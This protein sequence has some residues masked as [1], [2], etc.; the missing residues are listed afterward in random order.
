M[1]TAAQILQL[2]D[3]FNWHEW[4]QDVKPGFTKI[5]TAALEDIGGDVGNNHGID[6]NVDDPFVTKHMTEYIG[7][8]ITQLSA[9]SQDQVKRKIQS[10][11]A[12]LEEDSSVQDL[13]DLVAGAVRD[14]YSG[15]EQARAL[16]I[17]RTE[18]AIV[19]NHANVLGGRQAGF[20][21]FDVVDGTDD[22]ECA[23][24]N[25]QT[26]PTQRCL[27]EPI[28][29]PHCVRAFFAHVD[30][31]QGEDDEDESASATEKRRLA[32]LRRLGLVDV[33]KK[34]TR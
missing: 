13:A 2:V 4:Q 16:R 14:L 34:R 18:S 11:L 24:A 25:G 26:W 12:D 21:Q 1:K 7:E 23:E 33:R 10:A 17:A 32:H 8:R 5:Y 19:Y 28:A 20:D 27:D 22:D 15:Y 9:T 30:D 6:F 31:D 3:D 29:H